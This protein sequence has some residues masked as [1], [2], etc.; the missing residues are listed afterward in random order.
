[1]KVQCVLYGGE[2]VPG[3]DVQNTRVLLN[4][5]KKDLVRSAEKIVEYRIVVRKE[6]NNDGYWT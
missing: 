2:R 1:M 5:Q 6:T 4:W 3:C